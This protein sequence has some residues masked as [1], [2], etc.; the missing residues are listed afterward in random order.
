MIEIKSLSPEAGL[1]IE[2]LQAVQHFE[3]LER[4]YKGSR[5]T[6]YNIVIKTIVGNFC[7]RMGSTYFIGSGVYYSKLFSSYSFEGYDIKEINQIS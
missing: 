1:F 3:G 2:N 4:I 6:I 7:I 5:S